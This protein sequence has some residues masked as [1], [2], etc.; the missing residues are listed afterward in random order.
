[1][2]GEALKRMTNERL[3][4]EL[5][6]IVARVVPASQGLVI[7]PTVD[8]DRERGRELK[9]EILRRLSEKATAAA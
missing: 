2:N 8:L 6:R 4:D 5:V 1:M 9:V 3:V 7:D